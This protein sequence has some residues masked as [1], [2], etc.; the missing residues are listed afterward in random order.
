MWPFRN[1][2]S[3]AAKNPPRA[4]GRRG[5]WRAFRPAV[6]QLEDRQLLSGFLQGYALI[7]TNGDHIGDTP[8]A[9]ATIELHAADG[10]FLKSTTTGA[11]GY[12]RFDTVD[13]AGLVPL[14]T[15]TT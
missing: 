14:A 8:K 9:G 1:T 2:S 15:N 5:P 7:D 11:D 6:T 4:R 10:S 12:Y 3:R 13:P